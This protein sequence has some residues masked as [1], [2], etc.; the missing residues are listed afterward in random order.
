M[1]WSYIFIAYLQIFTYALKQIKSGTFD[2]FL[3]KN[4]PKADEILLEGIPKGTGLLSGGPTHMSEFSYRVYVSIYGQK[5]NNWHNFQM[6]NLF[7]FTCTFHNMRW[8]LQNSFVY[9]MLREVPVK[10]IDS[11]WILACTPLR[12]FTNGIALIF[13]ANSKQNQRKHSH[14]I[15]IADIY[16]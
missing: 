8:M 6:S 11:R 4:S 3:T 7:P 16:C 15:F 14:I 5:P 13:T 1:L 2:Y 12:P 9:A 10:Y